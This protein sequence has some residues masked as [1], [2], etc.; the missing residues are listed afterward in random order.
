MEHQI[1]LDLE[2]LR[3]VQL[4]LGLTDEELAEKMGIAHRT[5]VNWRLRSTA[6]RWNRLVDIARRLGV[7]P[8]EL[9]DRSEVPA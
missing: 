8:S 7:E 1:K 9:L 3:E 2:A 4:D 5:L 6:P